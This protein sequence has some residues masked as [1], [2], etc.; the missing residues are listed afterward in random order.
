VVSPTYEFN[1]SNFVVNHQ[2]RTA[3]IYP[4]FEAKSVTIVYFDD[5]NGNSSLTGNSY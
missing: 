4:K 2:N 3:T 5:V 1:D